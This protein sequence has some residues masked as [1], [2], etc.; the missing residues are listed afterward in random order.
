LRRDEFENAN[1]V[2][3]FLAIPLTEGENRIGAVVLVHNVT[4]LR[5]KDRALISKD[6]T[7]REIH[8]RVKNNLQTVSAL[9]RLQ[10]RRIEDPSASA[11][12]EEAVRRVASIALVHETLSTSSQDTVQ[13]DEVISKIM[14]SAVELSTRPNQISIKKSGEF[15]LVPSI[16]A[17]PLALVIT[18]LVHNALEHG[19][20][21]SGTLLELRVEREE[22]SMRVA[23]IDDGAGVPE[24]FTLEGN[25]NLGLQIV[26]TLTLN[27]LA[28][29]IKFVKPEKGT[30]V[31]ITFQM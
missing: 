3:D 18:E 13:F 30:E 20:S 29:S 6:A 31:W 10:A 15:G 23:V 27:E 1:G 11:A 5:R 24:G 21:E 16:V 12:I 17:T 19:L 4:E 26:N 22:N 25:T 2:V 14:Q 9:L 8:H 28:G 7:I